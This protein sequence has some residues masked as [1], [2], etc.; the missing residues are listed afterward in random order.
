[1]EVV[2]ERQAIAVPRPTLNNRTEIL[3]S[4]REEKLKIAVPNLEV[5]LIC[6]LIRYVYC[7]YIRKLKSIFIIFVGSDLSHQVSVVSS[8]SKHIRRSY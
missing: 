3:K 7:P 8:C 2:G 6:V 5:V 1:M 4:L